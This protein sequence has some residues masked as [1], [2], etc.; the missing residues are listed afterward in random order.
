MKKTAS[1]LLA[2]MLALSMLAACAGD[3]AADTPTPTPTPTPTAAPADDPTPEPAEDP[4]PE[5]ADDFDTDRVIAVFT[6]EDGS[7]TR[8]AFVSITGVG[9]DMYIEAVVESETNQILTK[10]EGNETA[11]GYVPHL[12][13]I[14]ISD[15]DYNINPERPFDIVALREVLEV[16][17]AYWKAIL[18]PI[19]E[20]YAQFGDKL[21]KELAEEL[22]ALEQRLG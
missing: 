21:P 20:F 10:V 17:N 22:S 4:T 16:K 14:D 8:D 3:Q 5:P 6:R 18:P 9:D 15:I 12:H 7:G 13:D 19:K 11:I 1:V 2:L